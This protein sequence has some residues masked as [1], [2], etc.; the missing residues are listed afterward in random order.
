[1]SS[2]SYVEKKL[3]EEAFPSI[4]YIESTLKTKAE[5][6]AKSGKRKTDRVQSCFYI[7]KDEPIECISRA[8]NNFWV[9]DHLGSVYDKFEDPTVLDEV[10]D[11]LFAAEDCISDEESGDEGVRDKGYEEYILDAITE[12]FIEGQLDEERVIDDLQY[13]DSI[14]DVNDFY[15]DYL[16]QVDEADEDELDFILQDVL[17]D[18]VDVKES[19]EVL[20]KNWENM[21]DVAFNVGGN[22]WKSYFKKTREPDEHKFGDKFYYEGFSN[23]TDHFDEFGIGYINN[24]D[25]GEDLVSKMKKK[26]KQILCEHEECPPPMYLFFT[27]NDREFLHRFIHPPSRPHSCPT[28][29]LINK[30]SKTMSLCHRSKGLK[31]L[32][33]PPRESQVADPYTEVQRILKYKVVLPEP[34]SLCFQRQSLEEMF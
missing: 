6:Y 24:Y 33:I 14:A 34:K 17:L 1:M 31:Q 12:A 4:D 28:I 16:D 32:P 29:D 5:Q 11:F 25:N 8:S 22:K 15:N 26:M 27:N 7:N 13:E 21:V 20:D 30:I 19:K 23:E 18:L 10:Y 2:F 3:E 9:I